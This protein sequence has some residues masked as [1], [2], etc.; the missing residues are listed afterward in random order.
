MYDYGA[1]HY[2]PSLGRFFKIDRFAEKYESLTPYHYAAN[3]PMYYIDVNG[4][5]LYVKHTTG[6]LWW[7]KDHNLL[8][9]NGKYYNVSGS[10]KTEYTGKVKGFL[11]K[12]KNALN[13]IGSGKAGGQFLSD[14]QSDDNRITITSG[15]GNNYSPEGGNYRDATS[16]VGTDGTVEWTTSNYDVNG[17]YRPGFVTLAHELAH[18]LDGATGNMNSEHWFDVT[19]TNGSITKVYK[20][21]IY[22]TH[23]ENKIRA[24]HGIGLRTHY[25]P[26]YET[27]RILIPGTGISKHYSNYNYLLHSSLWVKYNKK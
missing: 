2:D 10:K 22:S 8:Y 16:G 27:S 12:T 3:N 15:S 14:L 26:G 21:E 17:S 25:Q 11:K 20:A 18:G 1:R 23:V 13:K 6:T 24:E 19:K 9:E 5:S 7:K 4:D